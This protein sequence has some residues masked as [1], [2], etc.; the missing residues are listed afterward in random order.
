MKYSK[1]NRLL[2]TVLSPIWWMA[3]KMEGHLR[4]VRCKKHN[5]ILDNM[6]RLYSLK[7]R[8]VLNDSEYTELK[9][10]LKKQ[11]GE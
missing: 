11:M 9:E 5:D 4:K 1:T 6:E 2:T 8:G 3:D 10:K 7:K